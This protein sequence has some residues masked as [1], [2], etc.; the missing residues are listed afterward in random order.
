MSA[1]ETITVRITT[2]GLITAETHGITGSKCMN[3][4][5]TLEELLEATTQSSSFTVDY[6]ATSTTHS[7]EVTNELRQQS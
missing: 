3:Y 2:Q 7:S 4:I 5:A 1:K 6:H